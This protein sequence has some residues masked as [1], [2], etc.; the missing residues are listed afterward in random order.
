MSKLFSGQ[1]LAPIVSTDEAIPSG[2]RTEIVIHDSKIGISDGPNLDAFSRLR[3]STPFSIFNYVNSYG[4]D[5]EI[6]ESVLNG[7]GASATFLP[8]ESS[9]SMAVGTVNGEYAIRQ[10]FRYFP[11][12]PGKSQLI[13]LTGVLGTAVTNVVKRLGYF[14]NSNGFFFELTGTTF[15]VVKRSFITGTVVD[16]AIAQSGWNLDKLDGTGPSGITLDVTKAQIFIIDFQ[17]LGVGRVR[18]GFD[19]NGQIIYCHEISHANLI[20]SV[21]T[22]TPILPIRYEI[23]NLGTSAGSTMKQICSSVTSEG[24]IIPEGEQWSAAHG[25]SSVSVTTRRPIFAIRMKTLLNSKTNRKT[26]KFL[27]SHFRATTNDAFVEIMHCLS[28]TTVTATW[29][30]AGSDSGVEYSTDISAATFTSAHRLGSMYC[31]AG[32]LTTGSSVES[33]ELSNEHRFIHLDYAG[34]TS[35]YIVVFAT[36]FSLTSNVSAIIDWIEY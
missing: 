15:N 8:D 9:T 34:T 25:I 35:S 14:D 28:P 6:F 27:Q 10:T 5:D 33:A 7:V 30:S 3:T 4:L 1:E 23:R 18:Y 31:L 13:I 32:L 22:T 19:V 16:T 24:G 17:W 21:Y 11:Y 20:S 26:V 36:S 29:T 2:Y 12:T